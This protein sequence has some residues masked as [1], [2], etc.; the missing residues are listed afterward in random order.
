MK[1]LTTAIT[2]CFAAIMLMAS[3][4]L[5]QDAT[6]FP[7][8]RGNISARAAALGGG[9]VAMTNDLGMVVLNPAGLSTVKVPTL[10]ATFVKHVLDINSGFASYS[11]S[12]FNA[13]AFAVTAQY[14]S[15]GTFDATTSAGEITGSFTSS[16]VVVAA[17]FSREIDTL[18]TWGATVKFLH[19]AIES[20][21]TTAIAVDAGL[22]I[23]IPQSRTNIGLALLNA[24][25]QVSTYDGVSD[26]LPT[27]LRVG[28]NHRL[29][30]LPLLVNAS[31][32]H[33][34]DDVAS[35]FDRFLN[36]SVGGEL[37]IG[38]Y[39]FARVG[40]DN[41]TR[42]LSDVNVATQL[43]GVSGGL[44]VYLESVR[45]DYALSTMGSDAFLHRISVGLD[46]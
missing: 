37:S 44:G 15:Y 3:P 19:G 11:D 23:Q 39:V 40:Y 22:L 26:K 43:A 4:L 29:K 30:G 24:G 10:N 33:L 20:Q 25:V 28:I 7:F 46:L 41:A 16:D 38:K 27:D 18:I 13:G 36:F 9:T 5:A 35:F 32:N 21:S 31:L 34:T 17:S 6:I 1:V 14:T 2:K 45:M 8:L 12:L 42:N